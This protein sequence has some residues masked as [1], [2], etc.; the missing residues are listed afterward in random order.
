MHKTSIEL[1][2]DILEANR[3]IAESN[4]KKL[5]KYGIKSCDFQGAIGSGKTSIIQ[6]LAKKLILQ[7]KKVAAIA[8]DCFGNDDYREFKKVG[9]VAININ[10]GKECH[11]DAHLIE[12]A[13]DKLPL[14]N[15]DILFVENVGNLV[16]PADFVLGM[17]K[18]AVVI[19]V[20]EGENMIKKH[21]VIFG[22]SNVTILNK[23][24]LAAIMAV[25]TK[26][27]E[28]DF[29]KINPNG[30]FICTSAKTEEGIE[31]LIKY[32]EL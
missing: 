30:N 18:R 4:S 29:K 5:K 15:I 16:C 1:E 31:E 28:S 22:L 7:G 24:D 10:T 26:K 9:L 20:T 23:V 2:K 8:G 27:L 17:D 19:S 13:L 11:L 21:P 6:N 25:D 14:K 3:R 32:L 12:K